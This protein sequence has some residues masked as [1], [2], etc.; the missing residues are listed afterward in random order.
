MKLYTSAERLYI[1]NYSVKKDLV[2]ENNFEK[3]VMGSLK[4]VRDLAG[5]GLFTAYPGAHNWERK[6]DKRCV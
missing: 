5:D 3:A 4:E 2:D 1:S 6:F